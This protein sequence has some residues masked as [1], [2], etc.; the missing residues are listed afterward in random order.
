[1]GTLANVVTSLANLSESLNNGD[2][3]E[4]QSEDQSASEITRYEPMRVEAPFLTDMHTQL[5]HCKGGWQHFDTHSVYPQE[6]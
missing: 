6:L 4:M 2:T 3:S 5:L 1:M